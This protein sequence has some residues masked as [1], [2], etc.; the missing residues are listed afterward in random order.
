MSALN[1]RL[2]HLELRVATRLAQV[3]QVRVFWNGDLTPCGEHVGCDTDPETGL[4]HQHVVRL[5][6]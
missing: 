5:S 6:W 2:K 3:P 1:R 4:H